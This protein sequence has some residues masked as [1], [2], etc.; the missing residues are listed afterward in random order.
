MDGS[1]LHDGHVEEVP[2]RPVGGDGGHAVAF[3]EAEL[4]QPVGEVVDDLHIFG[5]AV[6][7]PDAVLFAAEGVFFRELLEIPFEH[8]K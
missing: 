5:S 8:I 3:L 6:F 4:H 2:L 1:D 7:H